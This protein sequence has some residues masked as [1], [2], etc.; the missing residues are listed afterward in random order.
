M[1]MRAARA[2]MRTD[3]AAGTAATVRMGVVMVTTRAVA[4]HTRVLTPPAPPWAT[5]TVR[6]TR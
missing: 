1:G 2:D 4:M 3:L 5:R 6:A